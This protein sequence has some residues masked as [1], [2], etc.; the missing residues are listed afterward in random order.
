MIV[1]RELIST[2]IFSYKMLL[3]FYETYVLAE[4]LGPPPVQRV[5]ASVTAVSRVTLSPGVRSETVSE[6]RT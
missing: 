1:K 6:S 5:F 3:C 4:V 2:G